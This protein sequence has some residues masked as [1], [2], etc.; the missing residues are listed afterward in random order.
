[1][2]WLALVEF[3]F[4]GLSIFLPIFHLT[5]Q[6]THTHT[7][8]HT[9]THTYKP[10]TNIVSCM[11]AHKCGHKCFFPILDRKLYIYCC[12]LYYRVFIKYFFSRILES[13]TPIPRQHSSAIGCTKK[14]PANRSDCTLA[15]R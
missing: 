1:M 4:A 5:L 6:H 13:L 11:S 14:L 7:H 10:H 9:L 3:Q 12:I 15:L 2:I 8:T